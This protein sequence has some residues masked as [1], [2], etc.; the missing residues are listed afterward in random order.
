MQNSVL[1]HRGPSSL[2]DCFIVLSEVTVYI[3]TSTIQARGSSTECASVSS[4]RASVCI[5]AC[6]RHTY[7]CCLQLP[8]TTSSFV[9][10]LFDLF[11][12]QFL[13]DLSP[14]TSVAVVAAKRCLQWPNV[15]SHI[16]E[17]RLCRSMMLGSENGHL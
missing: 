10:L 15:A 17:Y 11:P 6:P 5:F 14:G 9:P 4:F 2:R 13:T 8:L 7:Y 12:L 3:S 16:F 1:E